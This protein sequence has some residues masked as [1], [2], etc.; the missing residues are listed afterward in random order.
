MD[1][2]NFH[3][4]LLVG[5]VWLSGIAEFRDLCGACPPFCPA[6]DWQAECLSYTLVDV[7]G[8]PVSKHIWARSGPISVDGRRLLTRRASVCRRDPAFDFVVGNRMVHHIFA[9]DPEIRGYSERI[10]VPLAAIG[11]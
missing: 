10:D 5:T 6:G 9:P 2:I 7:G 3:G 8:I 1:T 11:Q 4:F